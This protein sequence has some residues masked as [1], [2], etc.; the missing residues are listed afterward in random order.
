MREEVVVVVDCLLSHL[1]FSPC[2]MG[3]LDCSLRLSGDETQK[4]SPCIHGNTLPQSS[5]C[6]NGVHESEGG[7]GDAYGDSDNALLLGYYR[8]SAGSQLRNPCDD[9]GGGDG[10]GGRSDV[11][12][13][14]GEGAGGLPLHP[15]D[16]SHSHPGVCDDLF[17][18]PREWVCCWEV[19]QVPRS[20]V[21]GGFE[22][23]EVEEEDL[24]RHQWLVWHRRSL[25]ISGKVVWR[26]RV[27]K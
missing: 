11:M 16:L 22:Q 2:H 6:G 24:H 10:D 26:G 20:W 17:D 8:R 9:D 4:R 25:L 18:G 23:E 5:V 19:F 13:V 21:G 1:S 7:G 14:F 12:S 27:Q 3:F 15:L